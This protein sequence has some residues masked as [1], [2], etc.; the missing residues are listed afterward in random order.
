MLPLFL[1][2]FVRR[3][4]RLDAWLVEHGHVRSRER[5]KEAIKACR[6][7]IGGRLATKPSLEV[8]DQDVIECEG[9]THTYVSRGA[10]KLERG[11]KE[12]SVDPSELVCLDIG[13]STGGFTEVLLSGGALKV[14]AVDVDH[15]QLVQELR[16]DPRVI[17]LEKTN[18]RNLS[19]DLIPDRVDLIVC[20][21]SF[22]SIMKALPPALSLAA[23]DARL[24]T[25]VKP[26]FELG[27]GNI[28]KGGIVAMPV[29][30]QYNW[31]TMHIIPFLT[32]LEWTV[33]GLIESP[34]KGRDG[35][36]EFL[37]GAYRET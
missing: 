37:L 8:S 11:L 12:W 33:Q 36:T 29:S 34:I 23:T 9:E 10:L 4:M 16:D 22:I 21:V 14:Y 13:A 35:N 15:G 24:V 3:A 1:V 31:I 18:S 26:Q 19:R 20:D 32:S 30:D 2:I 25:L 28:G 17:N 7:R 5:A 27:Q 6:V